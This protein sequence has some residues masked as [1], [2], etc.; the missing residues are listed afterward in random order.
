VVVGSVL[1]G[2]FS[3]LPR[4]LSRQAPRRSFN[5]DGRPAHHASRAGGPPSTAVENATLVIEEGI[6]CR[7]SAEN[8]TLRDCGT[9]FE[10]EGGCDPGFVDTH[11]HGDALRDI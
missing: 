6:I 3:A 11:C 2:G 10:A 9:V 4:V 8:P 7:V 1:L 5:A